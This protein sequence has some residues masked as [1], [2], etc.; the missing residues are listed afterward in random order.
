M[1]EP[2][3]LLKLLLSMNEPAAQPSPRMSLPLPVKLLPVAVK[4]V[5]GLK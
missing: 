5:V 1:C 4:P 3:L 2:T